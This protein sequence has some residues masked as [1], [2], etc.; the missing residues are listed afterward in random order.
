[1]ANNKNQEFEAN[2][3]LKKIISKLKENKEID[4]LNERNRMQILYEKQMK[5]QDSKYKNQLKT[6]ESKI[7]KLLD[8]KAK[9]IKDLKEQIE[10]KN[11]L[12]HKYEELLEKQRKDFLLKN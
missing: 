6:I 4:I 7:M 9:D 1:M 8:T 12:V 5:E 11:R 10:V 3:E 2:K